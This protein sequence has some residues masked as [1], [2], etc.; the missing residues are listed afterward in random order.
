MAYPSFHQQGLPIGSGAVES[1]AKTLVKQRLK[2]AGMRWSEAGA[3][4]IL[5]LRYRSLTDAA[6][7][8]PPHVPM[9]V[10]LMRLNV[11]RPNLRHSPTSTSRLKSADLTQWAWVELARSGK[12]LPTELVKCPFGGGDVP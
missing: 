6:R 10:T 5:Q 12:S 7:T 8:A 1:A 3:H 4:A 11:F 9:P 2:R